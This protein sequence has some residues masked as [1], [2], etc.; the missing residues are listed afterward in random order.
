MPAE[1]ED[2]DYQRLWLEEPNAKS[3][4]PPTVVLMISHGAVR[5]PAPQRFPMVLM[6]CRQYQRRAYVRPDFDATSEN[7]SRRSP[8]IASSCQPEVNKPTSLLAMK[9]GRRLGVSDLM[10]I[11]RRNQGP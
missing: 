10:S 11:S 9:G 4:Y 1:L 2:R 3:K 7:S 6:L 5:N 8:E